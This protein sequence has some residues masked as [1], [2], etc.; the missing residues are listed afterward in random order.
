MQLT[1]AV[2]LQKPEAH[3]TAKGCK[4]GG[5]PFAAGFKNCPTKQTQINHRPPHNRLLRMLAPSWKLSP[6]NCCH[7]LQQTYPIHCLRINSCHMFIH[8]TVPQKKQQKHDLPSTNLLH[9]AISPPFG[10]LLDLSHS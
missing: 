7:P 10:Q 5:L 4:P 8:D 2:E 9:L 3:Q 6:Q 1:E